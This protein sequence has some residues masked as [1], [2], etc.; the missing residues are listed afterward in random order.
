MTIVWIAH[1]LSTVRGAD[2]IAVVED[3][4]IVEHGSWDQLLNRP[5]SRLRALYDA[6]RI[7]AAHGELEASAP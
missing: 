2:T 7:N 4:R 1:R 6:Q 5:A 3:G